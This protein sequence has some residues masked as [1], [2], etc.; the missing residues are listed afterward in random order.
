MKLY[1]YVQIICIR[2]NYLKPYKWVQTNDYY[3]QIK[4]KCGI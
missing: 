2:Q 4:K 3:R 1:N